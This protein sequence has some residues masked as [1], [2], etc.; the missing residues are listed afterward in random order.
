MA[1]SKSLS[2]MD[3]ACRR[4]TPHAYLGSLLLS[5]GAS[6]STVV[7]MRHGSRPDTVSV[8]GRVGT[9]AK[10]NVGKTKQVGVSVSDGH[11]RRAVTRRCG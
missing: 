1:S 4:P 11:N 3:R 2:Q 6:P 8:F 10:L 7:E 9:L 5:E